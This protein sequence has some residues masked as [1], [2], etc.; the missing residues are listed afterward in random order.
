MKNML[1]KVLSVVMAL[2][3]IM[4]TFATIASAYVVT[5]HKHVYNEKVGE[6]VPATCITPAYDTMACECGEV[7]TVAVSGKL[8]VCAGPFETVAATEPTCDEPGYLAYERCVICGKG[9]KVEDTSKPALG[10]AFE[11]VIEDPSCGENGKIYDKCT[12]CG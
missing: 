8:T 12:R 2:T 3:M 10:H 9:T 6:T 11:L 1:I 4:G 5:E 7:K